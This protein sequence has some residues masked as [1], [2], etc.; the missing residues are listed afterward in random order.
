MSA[1]R[2]DPFNVPLSGHLLIQASAGTGKTYALTTLVA[3]LLVET[4]HTIDELLV[5]TFTNAAT[6]ELRDRLRRTLVATSA[7][8]RAGDADSAE[9]QARSLLERWRATDIDRATALTRI[10]R[11]LQDFD[12]ANVATIHSF[13]QRALTGIRLRW[14]PALRLRA[15]RCRYA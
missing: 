10:A 11:A 2:E 14:C 1:G 3:R 7:C 5:V 13:C 6:G 8:L 4:E 12:R 9:S 15:R